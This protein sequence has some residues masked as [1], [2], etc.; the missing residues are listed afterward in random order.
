M[1]QRSQHEANDDD[2]AREFRRGEELMNG[3]EVHEAGDGQCNEVGWGSNAT[4]NSGAGDERYKHNS[5]ETKEPVRCGDRHR[6]PP[7]WSGGTAR[8]HSA[9]HCAVLGALAGA[10]CSSAASWLRSAATSMS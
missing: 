4:R 8:L 6:S 7:L 5:G 9:S 2:A 3:E 10:C 1:P